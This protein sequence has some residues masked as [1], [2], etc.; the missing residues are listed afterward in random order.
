MKFAID[1]IAINKN[2]Q[3]DE[4]IIRNRLLLE[5]YSIIYANM[6]DQENTYGLGINRIYNNLANNNLEIFYS[7]TIVYIFIQTEYYNENSMATAV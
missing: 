7:N 4:L 6:M 3:L 5:F 2:W 1:L